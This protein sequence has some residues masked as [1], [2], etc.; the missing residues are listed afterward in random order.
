MVAAPAAVVAVTVAVALA[1]GLAE[2]APPESTPDGE[3]PVAAAAADEADRNADDVI[4]GDPSDPDVLRVR[5]RDAE[6]VAVRA[7]GA[8]PVPPPIVAL[9]ML[10][11]DVLAGARA[12]D[13]TGVRCS[14][15]ARDRSAM[16][17]I[18]DTA[19]GT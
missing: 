2:G 10:A 13:E 19:R 9:A 16:S 12:A 14:L 11:C 1:G 15:G 6:I 7:A 18:G 8:P 17:R 4:D 5:P 3:D